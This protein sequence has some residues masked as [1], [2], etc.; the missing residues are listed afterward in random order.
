[1][2]ANVQV[3][4]DILEE[5]K[6]K[7]KEVA[8]IIHHYKKVLLQNVPSEIVVEAM[9]RKMRPIFRQYHQGLFVLDGMGRCP[10]QIHFFAEWINNLNVNYEHKK[11]PL[12]KQGYVF[13]TLDFEEAMRRVAQRI[14]EF[15]AKGL[16]PRAEDLGDNPKKRYETYFK[17]E[18]TLIQTAQTVT[19]N[20]TIL[21]LGKHRTLEVAAHILGMVNEADPDELAAQLRQ[22]FKVA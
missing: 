15:K 11:K 1:M 18:Q 7:N 4:S 20:V 9:T 14:E 16:E 12:I 8:K 17:L 3:T 21:D 6:N 5:Y 19:G 22:K 13:L 2:G 10:E